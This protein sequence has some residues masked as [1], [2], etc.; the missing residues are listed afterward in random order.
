MSASGSTSEVPLD[1]AD[2]WN[3]AWFQ[4]I[5]RFVTDGPEAAVSRCSEQQSCSITLSARAS[6]VGR[7][8]PLQFWA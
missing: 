5:E 3:R 2:V 6:S 8:S 1:V 4:T 7:T